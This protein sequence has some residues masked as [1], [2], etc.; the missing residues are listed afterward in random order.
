[1]KERSALNALRIHSP[2]VLL[3]GFLLLLS[4]GCHYDIRFEDIGYSLD[5]KQ[6][7]AGLVSVIRPE[8]LEQRKPIRSFMAGPTNTWDVH[9]GEMLSQ[10]TA[11]ELPQ[12]ARYYRAAS[13]YEEPQEGVP[14]LSVELSLSHYDFSKVHATV[15][16]QAKVYGPGR[17]IIF[18]RL[19]RGEGST[20]GGKMYWGGLFAMK[21]A[22]RQSS[23]EAY[24]SAFSQLR[25]DLGSIF[26]RAKPKKIMQ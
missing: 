2:Y 12:L 8:T 22:I 18:D 26:D 6:F 1:M 4:T 5:Q 14:R 24:R 16:V 3:G 23:F 25:L 19:Y 17:V 21:S 15:V 9:P 20:Q 13:R 11:I 10:I 7:D